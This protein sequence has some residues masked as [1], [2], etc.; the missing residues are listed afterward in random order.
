M[1]IKKYTST[2]AN[3]H[4]Y[5]AGAARDKD[6]EEFGNSVNSFNSAHINT[7]GTIKYITGQV[8]AQLPNIQQQLSVIQQVMMSN[9]K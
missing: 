8:N 5:G 9:Q 6:I 4:I 1:R 3:A 7:Q 2:S